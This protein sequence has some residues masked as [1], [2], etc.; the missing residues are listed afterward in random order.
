MAA[1][2]KV[3]VTRKIPEV[4]L[5]RIQQSCEA[6]I[7]T[8]PLPPAYSLIREKVATCEGLVSLLSDKIDAGLLE[9]APR[10]RVVSNYAV[11]FNNI[12][13]PPPPAR[14]C[15]G[16]YP[17][18][19]DRCHGRHG[20]LSAPWSSPLVSCRLPVH[21]F[22]TMENLGAIRTS[23]TGL[24]W[25]TLGIVG[26]GRIGLAL[27]KRCHAG[28]DMKVIYYDVVRNELAEK[29]VGAR[30]VEFDTL[31]RESDFVS[32]HTNLNEKTK[33]LFSTAQFQRMKRTAVFV[34]TARGPI[35]D[36][37]ALYEALKSGTIFAAGLDVTD[38]EPPSLDN[39]LLS[40][41]NAIWRR[42]SR[43]L[44]S[45]PAMP[46]PI[47]CRQSDRWSCR[48]KAAGLA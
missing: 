33:G 43:V 16:Q 17:R 39:P 13:I 44:Q 28:W 18:R 12:D 2:P 48:T 27:A 24:G 20:V 41:P 4:G 22:R 9:G 32:V 1:K 8:D 40:L 47:L 37:K 23:G 42:T 30:Q 21:P 10:L 34:N 5:Q 31:L 25:P 45:I 15:R 26:M 6:E 3:L 38:P 46:W 36:E 35:V 29:E 11:G 7:W 19:L 14:H